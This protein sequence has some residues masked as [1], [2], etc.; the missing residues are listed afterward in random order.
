MDGFVLIGIVVVCIT[1]YNLYELYLLHKCKHSYE[2]VDK[3]DYYI[4]NQKTGERVGTTPYKRKYVYKCQ[5]CGKIKFDV[6]K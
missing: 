3:C 5:K 6:V 4:A 1:I 2:L